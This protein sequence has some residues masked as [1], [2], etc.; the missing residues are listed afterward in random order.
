MEKTKIEKLNLSNAIIKALNR[1]GVDTIDQLVHK[2]ADGTV[3]DIREIGKVKLIAISNALYE[4]N[5]TVIKVDT[6]EAMPLNTLPATCKEIAKA[7]KN[8]CIEE[9][10]Y[11]QFVNR[12]V[13]FLSEA[14]AEFEYNQSTIHN[15]NKKIPLICVLG[16]SASGKDYL[17]NFV[18][19]HDGNHTITKL[20]KVTTRPKRPDEKSTYDK[21]MTDDEFLLSKEIFASSVFETEHGIWRYGFIRP[22][23]DPGVRAILAVTDIE[24]CTKIIEE[25]KNSSI[26]EVYC[27]RIETPNKER[28][29]KSMDRES[30]MYRLCSRFIKDFDDFSTSNKLFNDIIS[31]EN[32]YIFDNN[33]SDYSG[34]VFMTLINDIINTCSGKQ[35]YQVFMSL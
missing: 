19:K 15:T 30:D 34:S 5:K 7:Y 26:F 9:T 11:K 16:P 10:N 17:T 23:M 4:Y 8:G 27:I 6:P 13:S 1:A 35:A 29:L 18:I 31:N 33:Y 20:G 21:F 12:C 28:F 22:K 32:S 3:L 24:Q 2:C 14:C 25:Y